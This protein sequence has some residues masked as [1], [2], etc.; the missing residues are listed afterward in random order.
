M[1]FKEVPSGKPTLMV[2]IITNTDNCNVAWKSKA[3]NNQWSKWRGGGG[4]RQ[5]RIVTK[6]LTII[7]G[8][9]LT[10]K[11]IGMKLSKRD[12]LQVLIMVLSL[13][14][15]LIYRLRH[16][17]VSLSLYL[18]ISTTKKMTLLPGAPYQPCMSRRRDRSKCG[19][20][21]SLGGTQRANIQPETTSNTKY[22]G[23]NNEKV[24]RI[25]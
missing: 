7:I 2:I 13:S 21:W 16:L 20:Q 9:V 4:S 5:S 18:Y 3:K 12:I 22:F 23:A 11:P 15:V 17:D 6:C 10:K 25:F 14:N 1:L 24:I 8:D 19:P